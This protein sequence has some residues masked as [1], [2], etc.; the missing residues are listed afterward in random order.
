[1]RKKLMIV[2]SALLVIAYLA[3]VIYVNANDKFVYIEAEMYDMGKTCEM[4]DFA[5][6]VKALD[7]Y[8]YQEMEKNFN[9]N[10]EKEKDEDNLYIL[11]TVEVEYKGEEKKIC[12][13]GHFFQFESG[14]WCAYADS[15]KLNNRSIFESGERRTWY[16]FATANE[17]NISSAYGTLDDWKK[18]VNE[19][20]FTLAFI[21]YPREVRLKCY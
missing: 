10:V 12:M 14:V 21:K 2:I 9:Y 4:E 8:D 3:R 19:L 5:Y 18:K 15:G 11:A 16:I 1:M 6:T 17:T 20:E 7:I 13:D